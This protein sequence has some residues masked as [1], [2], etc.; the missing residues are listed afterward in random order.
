M[1]APLY[2]VLMGFL[3][4]AV[5]F[6]LG[7]VIAYLERGNVITLHMIWGMITLGLLVYLWFALLR[8]EQFG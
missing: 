1:S 7:L 2:M 4:M 6:Q 3:L 8:P 5:V